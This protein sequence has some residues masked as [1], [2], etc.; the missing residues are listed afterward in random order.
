MVEEGTKRTWK[1]TDDE[2]KTKGWTIASFYAWRDDA[3]AY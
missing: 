2:F 3:Q 1:K